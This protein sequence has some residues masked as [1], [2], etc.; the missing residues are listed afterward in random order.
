MF[1]TELTE[2]IIAWVLVVCTHKWN[3]ITHQNQTLL[4][5]CL[6]CR[7]WLPASRHQLFQTL[8][9]DTPER[10]DLLVSAVLHSEKMRIHLLSVRTVALSIN[11][12]TPFRRPF[13]LEFAGHLPNVN[14]MTFFGQSVKAF[15]SHPTSG[16]AIS[17]FA[18]VQSLSIFHCEFPS[19]GAFRRTL[20]SLPSLNNLRLKW[21]SWPDPA[22][23]LSPSLSHGASTVCRPALLVLNVEWDP[24]RDRHRAQQFIAWLSKTATSSS[25]LY[26][27]A[28]GDSTPVDK[29]GCMPTFGPSV[30]RFGQVLQRLE[31]GVGES[32]DLG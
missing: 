27:H 6:V 12:G 1:P 10:Y 21:P 29:I 30:F 2:E 24:Q 22:A 31:I 8:H 9:I 15:L 18:L 16:V 28:I 4:S 23:D 26:L 25:L 32:R 17:R 11:S 14:S 20:T 3:K 13:V 7:A 5:C 19:F